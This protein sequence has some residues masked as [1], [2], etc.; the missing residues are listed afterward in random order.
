LRITEP[1]YSAAPA[2]A[3]LKVEKCYFSIVY[4]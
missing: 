1:R 2:S 3:S 4:F